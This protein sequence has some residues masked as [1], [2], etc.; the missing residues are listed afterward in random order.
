MIEEEEL[1]SRIEQIAGRMHHTVVLG[2]G[3]S[4]AAF[5]DGDKNGKK[6]PV[7]A[8]LF[9]GAIIRSSKQR[10]PLLT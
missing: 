9:G 6:L 7:M 1:E 4:R 3:A 5:P 8:G 10:G 2:A